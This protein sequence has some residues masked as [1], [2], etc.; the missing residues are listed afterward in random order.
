MAHIL[1]VIVRDNPGLGQHLRV[2]E[3]DVFRATDSQSLRVGVAFLRVGV[4]FLRV[5]P[6]VAFSFRFVL[7]VL[8]QDCG[9]VSQVSGCT[10]HVDLK[11]AECRD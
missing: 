1:N 8:L 5:L 11:R 6:L 3:S 7:L 2:P 4:A 10:G 9:M